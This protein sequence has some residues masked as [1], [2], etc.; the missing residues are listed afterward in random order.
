MMALCLILTNTFTLFFLNRAFSKNGRNTLEPNVL[1][2]LPFMGQRSGFT[3]SDL[4]KL[5]M[6]YECKTSEQT[7][8]KPVTTTTTTVSNCNDAYP[9]GLCY[10]WY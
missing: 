3:A 9:N 2:L 6:L 8:I 7:V 10:T 4:K 1:S 5:N